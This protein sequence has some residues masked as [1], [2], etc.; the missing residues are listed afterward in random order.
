MDGKQLILDDLGFRDDDQ[1]EIE[2]EEEVEEEDD[3]QSRRTA[4]SHPF[5]DSMCAV[6]NDFDGKFRRIDYD[7]D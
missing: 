4:R 2:E 1:D 5:L 6:E 7:S 3:R